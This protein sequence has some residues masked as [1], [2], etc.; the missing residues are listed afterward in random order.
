[1]VVSPHAAIHI[2]TI[3]VAAVDTT[4]A[5]D[6]FAGALAAALL[7]G[8]PTADAIRFATGAAAFAVTGYGAQPSYPTRAELDQLLVT[9]R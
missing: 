8:R 7:E 5:G 3:P 9:H 2:P 6:A 1:M 4:G